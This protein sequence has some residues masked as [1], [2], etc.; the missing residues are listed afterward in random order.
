MIIS[1]REQEI[2]RLIAHEYTSKE[3]AAKLFISPHTAE[4]H[5]KNLLNKMCVKNTAGL[6]RRAFESQILKI[7]YR[8]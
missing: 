2:L 4:S 7:A 8:G 3:I 5:R 1:D 6:V